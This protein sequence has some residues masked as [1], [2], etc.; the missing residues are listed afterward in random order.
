MVNGTG[1][2]VAVVVLFK[3]PPNP[4]TSARVAVKAEALDEET[5]LVRTKLLVGKVAFAEELNGT[6]DEVNGVLESGEE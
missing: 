5:V 6:F 2:S 4:D 3:R 1:G